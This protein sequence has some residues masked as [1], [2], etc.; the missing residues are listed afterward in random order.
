[1]TTPTIRKKADVTAHINGV[2]GRKKAQG[3]EYIFL[4]GATTTRPDSI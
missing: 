3:L 1:M 4:T 2:N